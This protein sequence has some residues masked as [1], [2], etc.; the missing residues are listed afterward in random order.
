LLT[1]AILPRLTTT[2]RTPVL[3]AVGVNVQKIGR[4]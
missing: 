1:N 4:M 2:S 3:R